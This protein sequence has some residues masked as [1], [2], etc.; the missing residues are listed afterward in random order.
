MEI[1]SCSVAGLDIGGTKIAIVEGA[2]DGRILQRSEMPTRATEPFSATFPQFVDSFKQMM[3]VANRGNRTIVAIS[4]SVGGPL[5]IEEGIL[6]NPPHLPGWHHVNLKEALQGAF[7]DLP[8]FIEHD[9]NAGALAELHFG[10][11]KSRPGLRHLIFLT[12]GTGIGA[13]IIVNGQILHG[14]SD[15]AGEVGHWRLAE[16]GPLAYGKRGSWESF[17]SGSGLVH[18]AAQM[19][20]KRWNRETSIREVVDAMLRFDEDAMRV[21]GVAGEYLGRGLALLID[22]FNPEAIVLGSLACVLEERIL[23]PARQ[24]VAEET[25][26]QARAAC[27]ILPSV[28]G[29][30]IGDVAALMAA[31]TESNVRQ[32]LEGSVR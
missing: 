1:Q 9:G 29:S 17:A 20:P 18:L 7:S 13:G 23:A 24:V 15:T 8:V 3:N 2:L 16:D 25:L 26:H 14:A 12:F 21:A 11:G 5:R 19:Y 28:L 31:L 22:A 27:E 32:V 10:I 6:L 30:R 4:V